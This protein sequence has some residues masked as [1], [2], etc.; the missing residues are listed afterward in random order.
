[1]NANSQDDSLLHAGR[2]PLAGALDEGVHRERQQLGDYDAPKCARMAS[3][4][5]FHV[6]LDAVAAQDV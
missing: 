4:V 6:P 1:M 2:H 3:L 5:G